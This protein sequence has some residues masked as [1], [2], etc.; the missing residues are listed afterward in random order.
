MIITFLAPCK[1]FAGGLKVIAA[2]G[3]ALIRR[4]HNVK[5]LYPKRNIGLK[6]LIKLKSRK[7]LLKE[8]DHLD[9]FNGELIEVPNFE[10]KYIPDSDC[11][12]ATA[13]E[14][15]ESA[16]D[17]SERCGQKFYLIQGYETWSGDK[18]IVDRTFKYPFHKIVISEWL[19]EEVQNISAQT[20]IPVI[21]N[22]KD[23][24][25]SESLGEGL[26]RK[27]DLGML[28]SSIS[29]KRSID[30]IEAI[31]IVKDHFN[32]LNVVLFGSEYPNLRLPKYFKFYRR[33]KQEKIK[34]IYLSTRIWIS[35]SLQEGFCLPVLE[36]ISLGCAV[37]ST[38]SLGVNDIIV[39]GKNGFLVEPKNPELLAEKI[40][41]VMENKKIETEIALSG[42]SRSKDFS[43]ES[44]TDKLES[45]INQKCG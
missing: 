11:L 32:D 33:P 6:N 21:P 22:G 12:I 30:G 2:Y 41:K 29:N 7:I 42:L 36:A 34:S 27:Y 37:I 44:S 4:G 35:T 5:V 45:L 20:N 9:Y 28:Y 25:L 31:K 24:F 26:N 14:T 18:E 10:E 38:N 43:W 23:F 8:K 19:R 1:D 15:A 39:D 17:Y 3:N 40:I 13:W 16:K